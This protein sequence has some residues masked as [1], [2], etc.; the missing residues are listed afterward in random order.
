MIDDRGDRTASGML[1][2]LR[3]GEWDGDWDDAF[4]HVM[5]RQ[6]LMREYLRRAALWAEAFPAKS[7]WPFFDITR[8]VDPNFQL[9]P[10]I[11]HELDAFLRTRLSGLVKTTCAGAVRLAELRVQHPAVGADGLPDLYEPLILMY[12]RGGE[13]MR[14]N[15][16][17]LDLRGVS[18]RAGKLEDNAGSAPLSR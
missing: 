15:A 1:E 11:A 4:A 2:R 17:A 3:A 13:F 14:D 7:S 16:G 6:L 18:F 8:Y 5:S 9:S 12:E 10:D